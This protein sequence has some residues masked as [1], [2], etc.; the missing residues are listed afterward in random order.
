L[1]A[2]DELESRL[3][4]SNAAPFLFVGAGVSRRYLHLD[5]WED[6]LRRMAAYTDR[7]YG[8]YATKG[9]ANLPRIASELAEDFHEI[10][11]RDPQFAG[12]REIYGDQLRTRQGPLKVEVARY[13]DAAL[14]SLSL[15]EK[16]SREL[17]LL[18]QAQVDGIIT[19]NYDGLLARLFPDFGLYVGQDQLLFSDPQ[20]VGETYHI[21]GSAKD[22][23]S[24]VLTE[25]DYVQFKDRN[26]YLAAKLLTIFVEH[27]ILFVGYSLS[28]PDITQILVSIA[29][30]LTA[31][32]LSRLR[33]RLIFVK[34]MPDQPEAT[35]TA[36]QMSIE[37]FTLPVLL[38]SVP[39]FDDLFAALSRVPRRFPA[40]VLRRLKERVYELVLSRTSSDRM[41]VVDLED[42]TRTDEI[43]VVFGVGVMR[44]LSE[45]GYLGL[46]RR[47]LLLD[48][49]RDTSELDPG[50]VVKDSLP[51]LL[52]TP[53]NIPLFRYLRAA[54]LLKDDGSVIDAAGV[55]ARIADRV[56]SAETRLQPSGDW[57][58]NRSA[59]LVRQA[60]G[61]FSAVAA[62]ASVSECLLAILSLRPNEMESE[63]VRSYLQTSAPGE[64]EVIPTAWS[65][66]V[67]AYDYRKYGPAAGG[68]ANANAGR[69]AR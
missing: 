52:R 6:L 41:A 46:T 44:R 50:L 59:E 34:W 69:E 9:G 24:I 5:G 43:D 25:Q 55:D 48:T 65:K 36:T 21:H 64:G 32:N 11:W 30:V 20:G 67:C 35:L 13:T 42:D 39:D 22:P 33:D 19:T 45:H 66:A 62:S 60:G 8:Y 47:D 1:N 31:E 26:P 2:F 53:G 7:P 63:A 27:P 56:S 54:G 57:A 16:R 51:A 68:V 15:D 23:E 17:S 14:T 37:G 49:L 58:K 29:R 61:D 10:W 18:S 12:S 28:D 38:L 3:R 4:A 40:R